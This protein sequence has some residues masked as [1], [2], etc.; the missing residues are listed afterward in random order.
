MWLRRVVSGD[1]VGAEIGDSVRSGLVMV[2][3]GDSIG[4][5]GCGLEE[6]RLIL[7]GSG[8]G[9]LVCFGGAWGVYV[10]VWVVWV[11]FSREAGG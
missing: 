5:V 4:G 2:G 1:C 7:C 8:G 3:L 10:G 9:R 6:V 11:F